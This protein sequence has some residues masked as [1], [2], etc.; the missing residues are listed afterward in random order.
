MWAWVIVVETALCFLTAGLLLVHYGDVGRQNRISSSASFVSWTS[1]SS[2]FS[3]WTSLQQCLHRLP[4]VTS[5]PHR[6]RPRLQRRWSSWPRLRLT[7]LNEWS[8]CILWHLINWFSQILTWIAL[9]LIRSYAPSGEFS[10]IQMLKSGCLVG[11]NVFQHVPPPIGV[12]CSCQ[13]CHRPCSSHYGAAHLRSSL[14]FAFAS[15]I[16]TT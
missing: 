13:I 2:S 8:Q 9:P 7:N 14:S 16:T 4:N 11:N 10:P 5:T 3:R 1:S 6:R 15:S 12:C